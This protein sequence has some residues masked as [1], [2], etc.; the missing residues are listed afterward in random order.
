MRAKNTQQKNKQAKYQIRQ[1]I[2]VPRA[3]ESSKFYIH[4]LNLY[5]YVCVENVKSVLMIFLTY[6]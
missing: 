5:I 4:F 1:K 6:N 2:H 3:A